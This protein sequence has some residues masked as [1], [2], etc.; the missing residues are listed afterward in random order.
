[1]IDRDLAARLVVAAHR[2]VRDHREEL[3][4]L[5]SVA[6]DGDHGVNMATAL[7]EAARRAEQ[8]DHSTPADVMRAAGSAFH[9]T[10]GGAAGAL[11]GSFFGALA[12]QLSRSEEPDARQ[13]VAGLE[14]GVARVA[15]VGKSEPGHK[16]MIDALAPAVR[17]ARESLDR[18]DDL[19]FVMATAARAARRGARATA[20][21]RPSAG[22]ARFAPDHSLGTEDPGANTVALVLESWA[23]QLSSEVRV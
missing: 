21:M 20:A 9:E 7:A 10:V 8:G 2:R 11:F 23:K 6:G 17:A 19:E 5:D 15:R 12:A 1:M 16:T 3:S 18:G 4:R 13:L 22:R 14:K